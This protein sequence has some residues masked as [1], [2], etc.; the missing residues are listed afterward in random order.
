M[1]LFIEKLSRLWLYFRYATAQDEQTAK[2]QQNYFILGNGCLKDN[3]KV[4]HDWLMT[5]VHIIVT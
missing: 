1:L 5:L 4:N 3:L 2:G